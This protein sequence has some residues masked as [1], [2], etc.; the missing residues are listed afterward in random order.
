MGAAPPARTRVVDA[1][2]GRWRSSRDQ[3]SA[4]SS[5]PDRGPGGAWSTATAGR[6]IEA[7][8]LQ[9]VAMWSASSVH[10][11]AEMTEE[12]RAERNEPR[13]GHIS[14]SGKIHH[15]RLVGDH[16]VLHY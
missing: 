4:G 9:E 8:Q 5:R 13:I 6:V 7:S 14:W 12:F 1:R 3:L 10:S 2:I 16:A 11:H 15:P